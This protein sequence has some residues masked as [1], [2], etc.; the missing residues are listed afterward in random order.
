MLHYIDLA[1]KMWLGA[2]AVLAMLKL[3]NLVTKAAVSLTA[4]NSINRCNYSKSSLCY[5]LDF[6]ISDTEFRGR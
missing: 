3:H 2:N 1:L 5:L 6:I 4:S